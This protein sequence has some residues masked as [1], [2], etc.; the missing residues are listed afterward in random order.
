[1]C[2]S[3]YLYFHFQ[4]IGRILSEFWSVYS[5]ALNQQAETH[6]SSTMST[7]IL[8]ICFAITLMF[9]V[10]LYEGV[11]L[12]K[13]LLSPDEKSMN[14]V[15][16]LA[17]AIHSGYY[18]LIL[19]AYDD[20]EFLTNSTET[21]Y[22]RLQMALAQYPPIFVTSVDEIY[23]NIRNSNGIFMSGDQPEVT[24]IAQDVCFN[25]L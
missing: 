2:H 19:Y 14:T 18:K 23:Y 1:V 10:S 8:T 13:L 9:S 21:K 24:S 20:H 16:Q 3:H 7:R 22:V 4:I 15:E 6:N 5:T 17:E 25:L 11:L 12:T